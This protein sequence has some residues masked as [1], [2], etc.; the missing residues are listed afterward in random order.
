MKCEQ[1][2]PD[3]SQDE[4]YGDVHVSCQNIQIFADYTLRTFQVI[5]N[6]EKVR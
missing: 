4:D 6:V 1:Y 3:V 2:W 5:N